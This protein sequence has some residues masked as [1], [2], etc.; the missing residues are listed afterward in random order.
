MRELSQAMEGL[1]TFSRA[2][3]VCVLIASADPALF[4]LAD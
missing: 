2:S 3:C 4:G 1:N